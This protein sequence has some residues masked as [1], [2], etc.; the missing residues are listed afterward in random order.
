MIVIVTTALGAL[1]GIWQARRLKGNRLDMA[2][3]AAG[4]GILGLVIGIFAMI[5]LTRFV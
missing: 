1:W 2:Q 4:F 3:Y 5:A